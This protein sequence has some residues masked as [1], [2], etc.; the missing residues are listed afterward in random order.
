LLEVK[1][2]KLSGNLVHVHAKT[3]VLMFTAPNL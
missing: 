3:E 2:G 1:G